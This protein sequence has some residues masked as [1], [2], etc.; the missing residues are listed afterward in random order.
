MKKIYVVGALHGEELFSLKIIAHL[1]ASGEARIITHIA[2]PEAIAK[3]TRF[4]DTDLNRSFAPDATPNRESVIAA[5]I[6][7][8]IAALQP[9]LVID[10]HTSHGDV[11]RVAILADHNPH[12]YA[13]AQALTMQQVVVMPEHISRLT[14]IGQF[15]DRGVALEFGRNYR[16]DRLAKTVAQRIVALL[17]TTPSAADLP[18]YSVTRIIANH[19]APGE[20]L[21]NYQYNKTLEGYPFLVGKN[22]YS[23]MRGFLAKK[24]A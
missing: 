6:K 21:F 22:T 8:D 23:T 15:P 1:R 16:S 17:K 11:G 20:E 5:Q 10:L 24:D 2:H 19:E 18:V 13:I 4:L 7:Q 12:L 14:L 3:K 9:D